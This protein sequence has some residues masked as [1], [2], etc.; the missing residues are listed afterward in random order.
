VLLLAAAALGACGATP[1]EEAPVVGA[2]APG[3]AATTLAGD[4]VRLAQLAGRPVLL[5][6]WATWCPPC[7]EEMPGLE[8]LSKELGPEG[9]RVVGVSVDAKGDDDA[10]RDFLR[11]NGITFT[12]LRDPDARV[13]EAFRTTG[14]P[15]TFLIGRDGVI[16]DHWIGRI[17]P[18]SEKVRHAVH[19]AL[20]GG[21][22]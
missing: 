13:S 15:E 12:I 18:A 19:R 20:E 5:N 3:Y 6:I 7:R 2:H 4:S 22:S 16:L 8:R 9:L 1:R 10:V 21:R 17:D 14:V 11:E